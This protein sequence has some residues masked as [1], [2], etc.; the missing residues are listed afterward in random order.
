MRCLGTM[1]KC[2]DRGDRLFFVTLTDGAKGFVQTPDISSEDA[3]RTRHHEMSE[4]AKG[5]GAEY[6]NLRQPDEFLYDTPDLRMKLIEAIR[7]TR[8][9]L[10][11]THFHEDYNLDHTTTSA[12][13]RHCAMQAALPVLTT[14]SD[15]LSEPP[16]IF[17]VAPFGTFPFPATDFVDV[18]DYE[19]TK[20]RLLEHHA[21]QQVATKAALNTGL[22][23]I[24]RRTDGYWG[25][26]TGCDYA[27]PFVP[28]HGR[29]SIKPYPVLP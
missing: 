23:D 16:A 6:L 29:C 11:F 17:M 7:S 14:T 15:P 3:A 19:K 21:S 20:I 24:C 26:Q 10:I 18:T 8:A 4:L 28:M 25:L 5:I 2:R 9:S 12:L 22:A 13:V 1:L 27:E